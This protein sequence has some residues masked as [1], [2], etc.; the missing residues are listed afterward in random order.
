MR[1]CCYC[2]AHANNVLIMRN[3]TPLGCCNGSEVTCHFT[4]VA[5]ASVVLGSGVILNCHLRFSFTILKCRF[6]ELY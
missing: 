4:A 1:T 3:R 6:S 2:T 5:V